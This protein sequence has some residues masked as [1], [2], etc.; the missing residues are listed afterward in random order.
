MGN[1]VDGH[2]SKVRSHAMERDEDDSDLYGSDADD[3]FSRSDDG[4]SDWDSEMDTSDEDEPREKRSYR[5]PRELG[6]SEWKKRVDALYDHE[7]KRFYRTPRGLFDGTPVKQ[8]L[9]DRLRPRLERHSK[10]AS[11]LRGGA[12]IAEMKLVIRAVVSS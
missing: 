4:F 7:F 2:H 9:A 12:L 11:T 1:L 10:H 3:C 6:R 8:G 5:A